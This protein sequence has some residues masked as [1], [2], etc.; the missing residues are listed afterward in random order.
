[1]WLQ[2][3][4]EG[5]TVEIPKLDVFYCIVIW[6]LPAFDLFLLTS[7]FSSYIWG[8]DQQRLIWFGLIQ[9]NSE[10]HSH[11][12]RGIQLRAHN[13]LSRKAGPKLCLCQEWSETVRQDVAGMNELLRDYQNPVIHW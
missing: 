12:Q 3:P 2:S 13:V 9:N 6:L 4:S 5:E 7:P 10:Q 1:M 8:S 11:R